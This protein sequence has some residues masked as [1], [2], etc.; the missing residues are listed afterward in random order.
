MIEYEKLLRFTN[1]NNKK[2]LSIIYYINN[3]NIL[4][5]E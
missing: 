1:T 3:L 5:L 2:N 4:F